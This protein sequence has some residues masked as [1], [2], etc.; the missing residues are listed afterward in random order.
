MR[1]RRRELRVATTPTTPVATRFDPRRTC[2]LE[3]WR[4]ARGVAEIAIE[5]EEIAGG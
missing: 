4:Q 2:L 1:P 3:E 5:F